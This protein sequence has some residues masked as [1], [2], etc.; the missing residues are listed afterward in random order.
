M[1][2]Y[3]EYIVDSFAQ[4]IRS[5]LQSLFRERVQLREKSKLVEK[6]F[7]QLLKIDRQYNPPPPKEDRILTQRAN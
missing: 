7:K 5:E 6:R 3:Q 2:Y 4:Q 1:L